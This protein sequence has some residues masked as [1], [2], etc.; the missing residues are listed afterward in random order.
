[1][2]EREG[3]GMQFGVLLGFVYIDRGRWVLSCSSK[4]WPSGL[5]G[6]ATVL[7]YNGLV[8]WDGKGEAPLSP[9]GFAEECRTGTGTRSGEGKTTA[10]TALRAACSM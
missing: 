4:K 8:D 6:K 9:H 7:T 10:A 1:M 2:E 5:H 3:F